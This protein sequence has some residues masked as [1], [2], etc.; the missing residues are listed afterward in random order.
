MLQFLSLYI[1]YTVFINPKIP[2][3]NGHLHVFFFNFLCSSKFFQ[4]Q[5]EHLKWLE[6]RNALIQIVDGYK[7]RF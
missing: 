3:K 7:R 6:N 2:F 5:Q 4:Q 1:V